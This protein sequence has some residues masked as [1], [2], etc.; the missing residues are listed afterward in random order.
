[1]FLHQEIK[2]YL[3]IK[4]V[5]F[6]FLSVEIFRTHI[7][8]IAFH[9]F[10]QEFGFLSLLTVENGQNL[11]FTSKKGQGLFLISKKGKGASVTSKNKRM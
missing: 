4:S 2:W 7:F 11:L 6:G 10:R 8:Q 3:G 1:M 5:V 9:D